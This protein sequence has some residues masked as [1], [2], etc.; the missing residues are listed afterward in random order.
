MK[1]IFFISIIFCIVHSLAGEALH[2]IEVQD[3]IGFIDS[4]G[5][6]VIPPIYMT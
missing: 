4:N 2:R 5:N 6:I 1:L 3:K